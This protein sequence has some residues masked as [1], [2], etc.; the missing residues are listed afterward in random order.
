MSII[1]FGDGYESRF[2][3]VINVNHQSWA[4]TFSRGRPSGEIQAIRTFLRARRAVEAFNW[5]NPLG[6]P[7][8]YV[9]RKWTVTSE[10]GYLVLKSTFE[11][12]FES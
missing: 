12:V 6:E 11:Q 3:N 7:G 10:E 1:Q 9:A 5:T 8:V 2:S 4:V